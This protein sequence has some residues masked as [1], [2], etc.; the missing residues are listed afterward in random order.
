MEAGH[1]TLDFGNAG[2]TEAAFEDFESLVV[3]GRIDPQELK[4]WVVAELVRNAGS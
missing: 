4:P 3:N 2:V 1:D